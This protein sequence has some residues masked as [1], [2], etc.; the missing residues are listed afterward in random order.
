[1]SSQTNSQDQQHEENDF[2]DMVKGTALFTGLF[3][4]IALIGGI[5]A[6]VLK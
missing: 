6:E 1:M 5:L 3:M 4:G 2:L